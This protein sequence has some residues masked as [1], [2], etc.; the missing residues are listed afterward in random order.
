MEPFYLQSPTAVAA[1]LAP[2]PQAH[3]YT[4]PL[5]A[6]FSPSGGA[7]ATPPS[8][9]VGGRV[10]EGMAPLSLAGHAGESFFE[11]ADASELRNGLEED[12]NG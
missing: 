2:A 9:F 8:V 1:P 5:S 10:S 4:A 3:N 7:L 12:G 11:P 6:S